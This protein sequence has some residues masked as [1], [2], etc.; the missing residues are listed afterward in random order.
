MVAAVRLS[1]RL[2]G[3]PAAD[4]SRI[5]ALIRAVGL[6]GRLPAGMDPEEIRSRLALDKKQEEGTTHYVMIKR[7][8]MPFMN[9]GVPEMIL[10]EILE[11]MKP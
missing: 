11:E 9:G 3:L 4:A 7:M 10:R 1:E 6:P 2:Y 5:A 8:G